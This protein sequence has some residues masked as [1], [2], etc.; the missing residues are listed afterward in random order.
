MVRNGNYGEKNVGNANNVVYSAISGQLQVNNMY[1][2]DYHDALFF[3]EKAKEAND[4]YEIRR[5]LRV[6][7]VLFITCIDAW[8]TQKI[9]ILLSN[10]LKHGL[11]L[12]SEEKEILGK[13]QPNVSIKKGKK[14]HMLRYRMAT[15]VY[16]LTNDNKQKCDYSELF[17][18]DFEKLR[19]YRNSFVH[20]TDVKYENNYNIPEIFDIVTKGSSAVYSVVEKLGYPQDLQKN[21]KK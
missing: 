12:D 21:D 6:A 14:N 11:E 5:Y 19:E 2:E 8:L 10:K 18:A 16:S 20:Y 3:L 1:M 13:V 7:A 9:Y 4:D 15:M 17:S